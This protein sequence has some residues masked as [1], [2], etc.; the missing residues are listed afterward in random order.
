MSR[1]LRL[2]KPGLFFLLPRLSPTRPPNYGFT[3]FPLIGRCTPSL[4]QDTLGV[5]VI[6]LSPVSLLVFFLLLD[7][8]FFPLSLAINPLGSCLI[9]ESPNVSQCLFFSCL[10]PCLPTSGPQ[11]LPFTLTPQPY[12]RFFFLPSP[13]LLADTGVPFRGSTST[14]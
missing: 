5:V 10:P 12:C 8:F 2:K 11:L 14:C 6:L 13:P 1:C 3:T 7:L 9:G 4:A